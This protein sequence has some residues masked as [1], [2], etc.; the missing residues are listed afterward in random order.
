MLQ[1]CDIHPSYEHD[2]ELHSRH[3]SKHQSRL[4]QLMIRLIYKFAMKWYSQRRQKKSSMSVRCCCCLTH[5]V[6]PR[7]HLW[8]IHLSLSGAFYI[9]IEGTHIIVD[10]HLW[11]QHDRVS[12]EPP[13]NVSAAITTTAFDTRPVLDL[14]E[15]QTH[16]LVDE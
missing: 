8:W 14:R 15:D 11:K 5:Y 2:F 16:A 7:N 3:D 4:M 13:C 6:K 10:F 9:Q 12:V 1:T